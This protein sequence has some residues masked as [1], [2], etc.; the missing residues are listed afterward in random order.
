MTT[1]LTNP[2][3]KVVDGFLKDVPWFKDQI[4]DRAGSFNLP[5]VYRHDETIQLNKII[6]QAADI[7]HGTKLDYPEVSK[8]E[9]KMMVRTAFWFSGRLD[10]TGDQ[11]TD[12]KAGSPIVAENL[13]SQ[14]DSLDFNFNK[15]RRTWFTVGP[16]SGT[17][18]D[19]SPDF[20]P[21][22]GLVSTGNSSINDPADMN[23]K[24]GGTAG[25]RLD[26][27]ASAILWSST[28]NMSVDF[29]T[30]LLGKCREAFEAFEDTANGRRMVS[31]GQDGTTIMKYD[32]YVHPVVAS[33][34]KNAPM[35]DGEK[36]KTESKVAPAIEA[37]GVNII[38][39]PGQTYSTAEDG[40]CNFTLVGDVERNFKKGKIQ[41][42][43]FTKW[44]ETGSQLNPGV[45]KGLSARY[46]P[47]SMPYFDGTNFFKASVIGK[48]TFKNDAG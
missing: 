31:L 24:A 30:A 25:T 45:E 36:V 46:V 15:D 3:L 11:Y 39:D 40:E 29:P 44:T 7:L 33:W 48:F 38:P 28:T 35:Y 32:L 41:A 42:P 6:A 14:A 43:T 4:F 22:Y 16:T 2:Y 34:F 1:Y 23:G 10:L 27:T 12:L 37:M 26:L 21:W 47:F 9:L 13:R 19:Y 8:S 17:D 20:I 5:K 18:L